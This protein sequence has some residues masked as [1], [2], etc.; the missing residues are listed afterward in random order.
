MEISDR[1]IDISRDFERVLLIGSAAQF[2][3]EILGDRNCAITHATFSPY[4]ADIS[5]IALIND[6]LLPFAT[7]SFDLVICLG[8]LE[9]LNDLP[10]ML[11]QLRGI[12]GP[13]GLFLGSIFGAGSLAT[14]KSAI[15]DAEGDSVRVHIHPQ[16]DL[17]TISELMVRAGFTLPVIDQDKLVV[18][19]SHLDRLLSD[20]RDMGL[21]N[22]LAGKPNYFGK[23]VYSALANT[24]QS[25]A[26]GDGKVA[27]SFTFLQLLG[28]AP[29]IDQPRPAPRGSAKV[30]LADVLSPKEN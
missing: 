28:W 27:E 25:C 19:Y 15:I 5:N 9:S 20:I 18:R 24:W 12:L 23:A 10:G 14:L 26:D 30:S 17:K 11:V 2:E 16:I 1:L 8:M 7:G 13:D 6:D 22:I 4:E 21:G 3:K 29:S